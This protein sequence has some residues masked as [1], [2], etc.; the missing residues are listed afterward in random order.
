MNFM[1]PVA[2]SFRDPAGH[3]HIFQNQILRSVTKHGVTNF[4][5]VLKTGFLDLIVKK[6]YLLPYKKVNDPTILTLLPEAVHVLEHPR[7]SY[8]SY[9]YEWSFPLLKAAALLHLDIAIEALE[10]GVSLSDASAYNIQFVG[11]Q[12][13]FIDHLSF[14]PYIEGEYWIAHRQF[15]E[16]FLN[17]LLLRAILGLPHNAWFRG[18]LEGVSCEDLNKLLPLRDKISARMMAHVVLPARFQRQAFGKKAGGNITQSCDRKNFPCAA[19]KGMLRQLHKWVTQL[20]PKGKQI[21]V[22][23]DYVESNTYEDIEKRTK[24]EFIERF[25]TEI[26][27][28]LVFDL[29]C[30][31][32][33]FS[34]IALRSGA[35]QVIG[36]DFDQA[37]LDK[38]YLR[39]KKK[40][41]N[42]LPLFLDAANPSPSQ[43]WGESERSGFHDRAKADAVL[44]LAFV[45]HLAIGRNTPLD[46]VIDCITAMAPQGVIE[47]VPKDDP[48]IQ[49]MLKLREDIFLDYSR[50]TFESKLKARA[51]IIESEQITSNGRFIYRFE[52][53]I[54]V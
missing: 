16:H 45:H 32:G 33:A 34:E 50:K 51:D 6:G 35:Q 22:W 47:F 39:A 4:E 27:P 5:A 54:K 40:S 19:Y 23:S 30:N 2:G 21:T 20:E 10:A 48:M 1:L 44:A 29:G 49:A 11:A 46:K 41:L 53:K 12:P 52:R 3:V 26:K 15:C 43:G 7:L 24:T 14:K 8:V 9:P 17:P 36:F 37:A 42:Y 18:T 28:R 25:I 13:V 38:A 31:S